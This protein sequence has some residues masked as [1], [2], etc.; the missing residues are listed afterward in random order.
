MKIPSLDMKAHLKPI[1]DEIDLAIKRVLDCGGFILGSEVDALES[2]MVEFIGSGN[3]VG[4][5]NGTDAIKL[6]LQAL[7]IERGDKVVCPSFTYYATAGAVAAIGAI[8]VFADI[9]PKTYCIDPSSLKDLLRTMNNELSTIKAI[10]PVHLYGQAADMESILNIAEKNNIKVIEDNAQALGAI[11]KG[12][13]V[14]SLGDCGTVSLFPGKNLGAC[15]DA[16]LILVKDE[17][18]FK[19]LKVLRNQGSDPKDKYKHISLGHN[20]RL[21]AI[22]AAI[23]RVKLKYIDKWNNKRSENASCYNEFLKDSGLILP[24]VPE[25]N[26]HIYHQYTLKAGNTKQRDSIVSHLQSKNI[27]SRTFYPIPLHLQ[28]CFKYLGYK[29]GDFPNS[30]DAAER[31]FS[32]PV[33]PEI[34]KEQ[35][36][37]VVSSIKE[38]L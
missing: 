17:N 25:S 1:R 4:V 27:D 38:I 36:D 37:Y 30:E 34:S 2:E 26:T 11:Y 19:K 7:G 15:G 3:A 29:P 10:I 24:Y 13:R 8:P 22:Q 28:P 14:G 5:S 32:I 12:K 35:M 18:V 20:N 6:S 9:D 31:V 23:I 21:D 33:Y 16:G